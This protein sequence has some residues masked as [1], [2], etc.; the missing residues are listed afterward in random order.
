MIKSIIKCG[1]GST[2]CACHVDKKHDK[3][4]KYLSKLI[5]G[6][7]IHI[8]DYQAKL[9]KHKWFSDENSYS[10]N[11]QKIGKIYLD[12]INLKCRK[13]KDLKNV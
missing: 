12:D 10:Y 5:P 1:N 3:T 8:C 7:E 2:Y 6:L 4:K 11:R 9:Y 13:N